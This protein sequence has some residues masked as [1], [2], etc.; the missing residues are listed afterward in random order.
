MAFEPKW[1]QSQLQLSSPAS[2]VIPDKD[3]A[4]DQ[5]FRV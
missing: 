4:G 3:V 5:G 2:P 1:D